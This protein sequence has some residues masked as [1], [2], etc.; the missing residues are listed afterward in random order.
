M[1]KHCLQCRTYAARPLFSVKNDSFFCTQKC[2]AKWALKVVEDVNEV[3]MIWCEKHGWHNA[4]E[5]D[6]DCFRC[7]QDKR[8]ES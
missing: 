6:G 8:E 7:L 3:A 1:R 4:K 5:Y 2:A